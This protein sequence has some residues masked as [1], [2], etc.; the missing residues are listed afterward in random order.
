MTVVLL[1]A[2]R[3]LIEERKPLLDPPA[4]IQVVN[5]RPR[6]FQRCGATRN[7]K[8]KLYERND[9]G[10]LGRVEICSACPHRHCCWLVRTSLA[11]HW[12]G[13]VWCLQ[14]RPT[15][16]GPQ[17]FSKCCGSVPAPNE[18]WLWSTK[19]TSSPPPPNRAS[20][21]PD[22]QRFHESIE[23]TSFHD[24][25]LD[26]L[27]RSWAIMV[28]ILH[29]RPQRTTYGGAWRF[30]IPRSDWSAEVQRSGV[31]RHGIDF[32]FL[33][34][35]LHHL[36]LS[37]VESRLR[38]GNGDF[39]FSTRPRFGDLIV[40]SGTTDAEFTRYRL[41]VK[42]VSPYE[43]HKFVH[44]GTRWFNIC[45]AIGT[46]R[47]FLRHLDQ[48]LDFFSELTTRRMSE[49]KRVLLIAKKC[50]LNSCAEGMRDRFSEMRTQ[51]RVVTNELSELI[52]QDTQAVP[53]ISYGAIGTNMFEYFDVALCLT[54]YYVTEQIVSS[55]LQ[56]LTRGDLRIPIKITISGDPKRRRASVVN[57]DHRF[58]DLAPL[59]QPTLEFKEGGSCRFS[60]RPRSTILSTSRDMDFPDGLPTR[61]QIRPRVLVAGW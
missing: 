28:E 54:G 21:L 41:G 12:K 49:S 47:Y 20:E 60:R 36:A 40:F 50:F 31:E 16:R 30:P 3:R 44:S 56:D 53:M 52:I 15:C 8:W 22:L 33:G 61:C 59:T 45:S 29:V 55:C 13:P 24:P 25:N 37:S 34:F 32:R 42:L 10:A 18:S 11:S 1:R 2:R 27:N 51:L 35:D 6:P 57:P 38:T 9:L 19:L 7:E 48:I 43:N 4:G 39:E 58:C 5:L 17:D 46:R 23:A 26:A 14:P